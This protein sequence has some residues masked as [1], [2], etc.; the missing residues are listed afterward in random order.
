VGGLWLPFAFARLCGVAL[1]PALLGVEVMNALAVAAAAA[2]LACWS[3]VVGMDG[4]A[5]ATD[6][7]RA[8]TAVDMAGGREEV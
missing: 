1:A 8:A 6:A 5:N 2:A 4:G 3:R 7:G